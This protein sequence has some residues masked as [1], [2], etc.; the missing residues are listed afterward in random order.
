MAIDSI[1]LL[2]GLDNVRSVVRVR[3]SLDLLSA[4]PLWIVTHR[5]ASERA[6]ALTYLLER[7]IYDGDRIDHGG[8]LE[9]ARREITGMM[10]DL[11]TLT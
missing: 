2:Q 5:R 3:P 10:M 8:H 7:T 9:R 11:R 6:S 4:R 1:V